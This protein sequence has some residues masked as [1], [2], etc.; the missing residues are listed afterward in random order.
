MAV[1]LLRPYLESAQYQVPTYHDVLRWIL[2][3]PD[4]PGKTRAMAVTCIQSYVRC[5]ALSWYQTLSSGRTFVTPDW[6]GHITDWNNALPVRTNVLAKKAKETEE[7]DEKQHIMSEELNTIELWL[8][9]VSKIATTEFIEPTSAEFLVKQC[10]DPPC[11]QQ[12]WTVGTAGTCYSNSPDGFLIFLALSM[13]LY[14]S[15]SM[16]V[17]GGFIHKYHFS[18]LV[19]Q[20]AEQSMYDI[21]PRKVYQLYMDR[22]VYSTEKYFR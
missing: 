16:I 22:N 8:P 20:P 3:L 17:T 18:R 9:A 6:Q 14:K 10:K 15:R 4:A 21:M 19:W 1:L 7:N 12:T 13:E 11:Y 2:D 5:C